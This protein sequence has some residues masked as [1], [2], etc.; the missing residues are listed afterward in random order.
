MPLRLGFEA[1][2]PRRF[3]WFNRATMKFPKEPLLQL[4]P[5]LLVLCGCS[6]PP[7]PDGE[8][9]DRLYQNSRQAEA[10]DIEMLRHLRYNFSDKA[11]LAKASVG[12]RKRLDLLLDSTKALNTYGDL[13]ELQ[14]AQVKVLRAERSLYRRIDHKSA[15]DITSG[16][17]SSAPLIGGFIRLLQTARDDRRPGKAE[18][19]DPGEA[20]DREIL[21]VGG[22]GDAEAYRKLLLDIRGGRL[23]EAERILGPLRKKYA[24]S[25][26]GSCLDLR[27]SDLL[28]KSTPTDQE[29]A[30]SLLEGILK[31]EG[32]SPDLAE[33]YW[34]WR[35]LTQLVRHG[36]GNVVDI[37]NWDYNEARWKVLQ[38]IREYQKL[39]PKDEWAPEQA[40]AVLDVLNINRGAQ[41]TNYALTDRDALYVSPGYF[42]QSLQ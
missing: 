42:Y 3:L 38:K 40:W 7:T 37:P 14:R 12:A 8:A 21:L 16:Y 30:L 4:L 25:A 31:V 13:Q 23:K 6:K 34:K 11:D 24:G 29:G 35:T 33:V 5:I 26:F 22:K 10:V 17:K 36:S 15:D 41:E 27:Q 39:Y 19:V 2:D 9:M 20:F 18:T 1:L 32:Y 28:V